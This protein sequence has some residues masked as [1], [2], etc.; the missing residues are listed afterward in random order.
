MSIVYGQFMSIVYS[1]LYA[2]SKILK[3]IPNNMKF[4]PSNC[5]IVMSMDIN[6]IFLEKKLKLSKLKATKNNEDT[7]TQI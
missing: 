6:P 7:L 3:S 1:Q 4:I 2:A 5:H